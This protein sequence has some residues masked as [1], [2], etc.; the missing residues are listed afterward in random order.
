[1]ELGT[2]TKGT[3]CL[4]GKY[5]S[6]TKQTANIKV[7]ERKKERKGRVEK[8]ALYICFFKQTLGM[9]KF[10]KTKNEYIYRISLYVWITQISLLSFSSCVCVQS[11]KI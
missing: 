8:N 3:C 6:G 9:Y 4:S 11:Y 1:M 7:E 5:G 10:V 2:K